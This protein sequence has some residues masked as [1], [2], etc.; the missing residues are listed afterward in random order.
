MVFSYLGG[1]VPTTMKVR[2]V[3]LIMYIALEIR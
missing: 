3:V 1:K 2:L